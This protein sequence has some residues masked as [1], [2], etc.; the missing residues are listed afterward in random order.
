MEENLNGLSSPRRK[1]KII[2][3]A[4]IIVHLVGF[5][6][7]ADGMVVTVATLGAGRIHLQVLRSVVI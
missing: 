5:A 7:E 3:K 6:T 1:T 2:P 4:M